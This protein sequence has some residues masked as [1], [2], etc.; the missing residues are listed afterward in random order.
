M[1]SSCV[2]IKYFGYIHPLLALLVSSLPSH[3]LFLVSFSLPLAVVIVKVF[4][5][6]IFCMCVPAWFICTRTEGQK[7]TSDSLKLLQVFVSCHV[8]TEN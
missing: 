1:T 2:L 8:D 7:R 3:T 4:L 6:K 5:K